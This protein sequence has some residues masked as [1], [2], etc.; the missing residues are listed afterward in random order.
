M[1]GLELNTTLIV[2]VIITH[3]TFPQEA[4]LLYPTLASSSLGVAVHHPPPHPRPGVPRA[5]STTLPV[6]SVG[7]RMRHGPGAGV[8]IPALPLISK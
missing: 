4:V 6:K 5:E 3:Y 1:W 2:S 8:R 7:G